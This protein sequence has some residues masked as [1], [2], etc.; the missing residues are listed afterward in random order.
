MKRIKQV[1][2][3]EATVKLDI[4]IGVESTQAHLRKR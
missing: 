2:E 1:E 4:N 3:K